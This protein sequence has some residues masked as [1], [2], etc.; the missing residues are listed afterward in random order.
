VPVCDF[1]ILFGSLLV[2]LD[3]LVGGYMMG[4]LSLL[5]GEIHGY[6]V[7]GSNVTDDIEGG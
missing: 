5:V 2:F 7:V 4:V 3:G 1:L 6:L